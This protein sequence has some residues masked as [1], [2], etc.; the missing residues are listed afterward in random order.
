MFEVLGAW[1]ADTEPPPL[2]LLFD[3]HSRHCS[4]RAAQWWDRLPVLADTERSSLC[5]PAS[6]ALARLV[7]NLHELTRP[8]DRLAGAY[9]VALPRVWAGYQSHRQAASEPGD[10]STIRT[11]EIVSADIAA[12]W[13][14]G[15]G[16]LQSWLT[17]RAAVEKSAA[18]VAALEE[19]LTGAR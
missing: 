3:R 13:Q 2:R 10:G 5:A 14:A 8:V 12:D 1:V 4:W 7:G 6:P 15:E 18:T 9:R 16:V 19:I 11:L 17:D